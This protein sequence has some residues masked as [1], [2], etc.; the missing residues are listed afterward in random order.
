MSG[1]NIEQIIQDEAYHFPYHYIAQYKNGFKQTFNDTW[2]MCYVSTI[3]FLLNKLALDSIS[4][5]ADIGTG[6]GRLVKDMAELFPNRRIVGIDYSRK[7]INLARALNPGLHFRCEDI[8]NNINPDKFD[9]ITLIEVFEHIP[10][11]LTERFVCGLVRML[12]QGG[13][14][15]MTVPHINRTMDSRHYQH[16][17]L[18]KIKYYFNDYF[19]IE[20]V[21]YFEQEDKLILKIIHKIMTNKLF[22]LNNQLLLSSFYDIYKRKYFISQE[23]FCRRIFVKLKKL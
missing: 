11:D 5:I 3:E 2:G 13:Y 1:Y 22:I 23:Q 8:V 16:F 17:T 10:L 18:E 14:I 4:S 19:N 9:A 7:A 15:Y 12:N 20:E 21:T 6:D